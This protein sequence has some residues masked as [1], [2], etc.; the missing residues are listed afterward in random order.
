MSNDYFL[1]INQQ[2]KNRTWVNNPTVAETHQAIA[3]GAL[4]CTT[5]PT[6]SARIIRE[7]AAVAQAVIRD[8]IRQTPDNARAAHQVQQELCARL[9][10]LFLPLYEQTKAQL[11]YVSVQGD[12][13]RDH[14]A[15]Y[16]IQECLADRRRLGPNHIAKIP[17]TKAGIS[18]IEAMVRENIPSIAT[19][20]FSLAQAVAICEAYQRA[21]KASGHTPAFYVTHIT[22]I[23]D[24]YIEEYVRRENIA[25]A[26]AIRQQ[27]GC[28]VARQQYRLMQERGYPGILLGGGVRAA[29]HFT[30][31]IGG[32]AHVTLNPST[33]TELNTANPPIEPRLTLPADPAVVAEL[34]R[35]LPPFR[36]AYD[37]DGL[38]VEEFAG[39][40]PVQHFANIFRKGWD[41]LVAA[42]TAARG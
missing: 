41:T 31:L 7:E 13:H 38:A 29:Y 16:I 37:L 27:A 12:P 1:R 4:A 17:V 11:G 3:A 14:D 15:D 35:L 24:E 34:R 30:E 19:E 23:Y 6:Y 8:A 40:G 26:P 21:A 32:T 10:P 25:I 36:Q 20:I 2:T 18:A 42:V 5:N 39:Y 28:L 33:I 22:G 9:T